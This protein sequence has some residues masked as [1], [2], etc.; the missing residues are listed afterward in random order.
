MIRFAIACLMLVFVAAA[1]EKKQE[2]PA[3]EPATKA[4]PAP[5]PAAAPEPAAAPA[6]AA[7]PTGPA[8]SNDK[9]MLGLDLKPMGKW[10]PT[11]DPDAKVAKWENDDYMFSIV[12]RVVTDK[13]DTIDEL[14]A[15]APMM[16]QLGSAITK[17]VEEKKTD[18]GW[19]AVVDR[20]GVTEIVYMQKYGGAQIVCSANLSKSD[21]GGTI[22]KEEALKACDSIQVKK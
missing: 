4:A 13:L 9:E 1:C 8:P 21:M 14:K 16:M 18:K 19:Y 6:V 17:V 20:E 11:W 22:K 2:A 10:K 7:A 5:A 12:I 15:A 3:P